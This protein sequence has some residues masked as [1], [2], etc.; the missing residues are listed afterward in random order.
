MAN[1]QVSVR[2]ELQAVAAAVASMVVG[3]GV[4]LIARHYVD[5]LESSVL[6]TLMLLPL[7]AYLIGSGRVSEFKAPGGLEAKFTQAASESVAPS[8]ETIAYDDP[9]LIAKLSVRDLIERKA[10]EIDDSQPIIMTM[11][12]S[13]NA[14]YNPVDV[15]QYLKVL[16]QFRNFKFVVFLDREDRFVAYIPSWALR[17]LLQ[18]PDLAGEFINAI[19]MGQA[20]QVI[21]YPGVVRKT[22]SVRSTN[23]EAL[24]EMLAQ[25]IEALLVVDDTR[26]LR[27]VIQREQ[28]LSRMMLSLVR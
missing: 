10:H 11:T 1:E 12:L 26:K 13:G 9:Q 7:L 3:L 2:R 27:G 23:A 28:V 16:S 18:L 25:N 4:V 14:Q 5:A 22:I 24:R 8:S 6:I 20:A 17:Q 19:N 21:R 15:E